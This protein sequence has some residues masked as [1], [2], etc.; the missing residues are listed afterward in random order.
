M[1]LGAGLMLLGAALTGVAIVV[2]GT[3]LGS[4]AAVIAGAL[5]AV[6]MLGAW[7]AYPLWMRHGPD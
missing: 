5:T 7:V 2:F 1:T 4:R 3:V 6:M